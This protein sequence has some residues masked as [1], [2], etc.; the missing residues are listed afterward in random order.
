MIDPVEFP[1]VG[2]TSEQTA[3]ASAART[4]GASGASMIN[5]ANRGVMIVVDITAS[6]TGNI[7]TLNVQAMGPSG[8]YTTIYSFAALTMSAVGQYHFC[9]YPGAASAGAW[10]AA[11]LQGP[12]PRHFRVIT[13]HTD[14][15]S[16]TYSVSVVQL[17]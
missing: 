12:I 3:L 16:I 1:P 17:P 15:V 13:T 8:T 11:P 14:A 5:V 10:K 7:L 6:T 9:I 2:Q 4:A